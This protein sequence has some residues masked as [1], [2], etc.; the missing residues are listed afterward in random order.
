MAHIGRDAT[1]D[2]HRHARRDQRR[3][4]FEQRLALQ[5]QDSRQ[6]EQQPCPCCKPACAATIEGPVAAQLL[7]PFGRQRL[8]ECHSPV[9][10][11]RIAEAQRAVAP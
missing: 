5:P 6:P 3:E 1:T 7:C 2:R 8:I 11:R 10:P 4:T 9:G